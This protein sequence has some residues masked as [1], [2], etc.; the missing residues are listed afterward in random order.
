MN[1]N[2]RE[3]SVA[4]DMVGMDM[5]GEYINRQRGQLVGYLPDIADSEAGVNQDGSMLPEQQKGM[6]LLPM[7]VFAD[8]KGVLINAL[9][10]KPRIVNHISLP[11]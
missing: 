6:D 11:K 5:G 2:I 10:R 3:Q 1:I 9:N 8:G 4:P 7:P